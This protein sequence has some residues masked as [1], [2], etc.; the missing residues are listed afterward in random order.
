MTV[1]NKCHVGHDSNFQQRVTNNF[2]A[3]MCVTQ[4]RELL[5]PPYKEAEVVS[6]F[7]EK[8]KKTISSEFIEFHT[9]ISTYL[10]QSREKLRKKMSFCP[11]Y[12]NEL[13]KLSN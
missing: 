1:S 6:S 5:L 13:A 10:T 7:L 2:N 8:K 9:N 11:G 4:I 3:I 12:M